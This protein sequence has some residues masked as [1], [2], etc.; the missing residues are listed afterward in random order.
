VPVS[1]LV[2][3][4]YA[5]LP[6]RLRRIGYLA[7]T[8]PGHYYSPY[9]DLADL[10]RREEQ[11]FGPMDSAPGIDLRPD[12]QWELFDELVDLAG[13]VELGPTPGPGRFYSTDNRPYVGG[14]A[15]VLA[16]MLRRLRPSRYVEVGS[17]WS[18][19]VALDTRSLDPQHTMTI[20]CIDPFPDRLLD[21]LG[22]HEPDAF[23]LRRE[24]V[25]DVEAELFESL[26]AGDVLFIDSTHV[27]RAGGDVNHLVFEVLPRLRPGVHVHIHDVFDG[28]EYPARWVFE[29]RAWSEA[30][31][32][33]AFL[34]FN[35]AFEIEL[36][37]SWLHRVDPRR[38]ERGLPLAAENPGA[39]LWLR[40]R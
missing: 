26:A 9:P 2:E 15:I 17:G 12:A 29:R 34:Q 33:R 5:R 19:A 24:P 21:V 1:S 36:Y 4:V 27:A 11:V 28:F 37:T 30:Y 39:Q 40:R 16:A 38:Y 31:L 13:D 10:R 18:T 25:Q 14:D 7:R 32:V 23:S 8:R 20:T 3:S 6:L 22:G 35:D